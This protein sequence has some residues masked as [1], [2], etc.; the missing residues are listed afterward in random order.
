MAFSRLAVQPGPRVIAI[1]A[2]VK[3]MGAQ[4]GLRTDEAFPGKEGVLRKHPELLAGI[5]EEMPL[6]VR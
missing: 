1:Q 5:T 6:P 3:A 2:A 4:E